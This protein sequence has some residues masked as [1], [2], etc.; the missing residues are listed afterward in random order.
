MITRD[1]NRA[2]VVI[3]SVANETPLSDARLA[4]LKNLIS[5]ARSLDSTRLLSAAMERHYINDTTQMIDDPLGEYLDV[6]GCNEYVGW[7]D[8]LPEKADRL[9]W[10]SKYQKPLVMSEFGGDALYGH[11]GDALTR[12]TEEYQE[13]IYQHQIAMLKKIPFLRG[14]SPWIL[15][16]FRS[17]RRPLPRIQDYWNRKGLISSR[18][19]KKKAFYVLQQWYRELRVREADDSIMPGAQAPGSNR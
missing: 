12:W 10:R 8:G 4:F 11:H 15:T 3:W 9:E 13:N 1:K 16:D 2:A 6:L 5:H 18:G 14:T 7:Y 19:E 17:P